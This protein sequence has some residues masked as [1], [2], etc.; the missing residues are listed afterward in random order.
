M[1]ALPGGK[2]TQVMRQSFLVVWLVAPW[3]LRAEDGQDLA[4]RFQAHVDY[5][6]A[7]ELEGR[8]L[9]AKG[10]DK[11]ADYI[12]DRF[13]SLGLKPAGD[14]G[15]YFQTFTVTIRRKM[16]ETGRLAF[17][18]DAADLARGKDYVPLSFSSDET[19]SGTFVFCG[20]GISAPEKA[21]DDFAGVDLTGKA[22][23]MFFEE[24]PGWAEADGSPSPH[25]MIRTKVY[26]AKDRGAV[27]V[28]FVS[29]A[30]AEGETDEL[31]PFEEENP[32]AYGVP[33]F[34]LTRAA[35]DERLARAGAR[36]LK[37]LQSALDAGGPH[38]GSASFVAE[39]L[40]VSGQA[41]LEQTS[42][43]ARNVIGRVPGTD[44]GGEAV[45]IGAHFDHLGVR[46]PMMREFKGGQ[47]VKRRVEPEIHN[48]ADDNASGVSGLIEI[49]R[50]FT[51]GPAP[52]RDVLFIAFT[53]EEAGL[54]GS[55]HYV[56]HPPV[57]LD[58]T[59][60]MLNMD[61]IGRMPPDSDKLQV[62][63]ARTAPT[64]METLESAGKETG[65]TISPAADA[66][67]RSDHAPFYRKQ[68]PSMHFFSGHH[69][70]HH[71]PSDDSDK[72]NAAA[73][74][75][76]ASLIYR[77]ARQIAD[78]AARPTFQPETQA[79]GA[80]TQGPRMTYRVVMGLTPGY[81][82]DGQPGMLVEAVS[83]E[84]PAE[85]AG[86]KAGDRIIRV[87]GKKIANIYDYMAST[88]NN[89]PGDTVEV[90]VLRERSE[91]SLRV[92]LS[93]TR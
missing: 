89:K 61:M 15:A 11:A 45:V 90:V 33:A 50:M 84:G 55:T 47:L 69:G 78:S 67:G 40:T 14:N 92:Q 49:A 64:F 80:D 72:I 35:V 48:G 66:G 91:H 28:L 30:L 68:V 85:M 58:R 24:P 53:G 87:N 52:K 6:A 65:L 76:I 70:D 59:V 56:N 12:A 44:S 93:G 81:V 3:P 19:F 74:A 22:A 27:A 29:P 17:S 73:G 60:A 63:G 34:H 1:S 42:A 9:G 82:N 36:S 43:A 54:L 18:G 88:R 13:R 51:E 75:K 83:K 86:M 2:A 62:F 21:R 39:K 23:L 41:G 31:T 37:D 32:D 38:G 79:A 26:N 77:V 5:L 7:D 57:P 8:G 71:K 10:I 16:T 20:Y 25:A 46:K 4:R